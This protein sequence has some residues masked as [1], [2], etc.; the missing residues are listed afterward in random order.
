MSIQHQKHGLGSIQTF[1]ALPTLT[2]YSTGAVGAHSSG[3]LNNQ[4]Y[5]NLA[6]TYLMH[7]LG[8]TN[9]SVASEYTY[10]EKSCFISLV[11]SHF[12]LGLPACLKV[13]TMHNNMPRLCAILRNYFLSDTYS[14]I[15]FNLMSI[16]GAILKNTQLYEDAKS[17][18][19]ACI[20]VNLT[21]DTRRIL[22][23]GLRLPV[24]L[25]QWSPRVNTPHG[26][27]TPAD[28]AISHVC[29]ALREQHGI[30]KPW[31]WRLCPVFTCIACT[32]NNNWLCYVYEILLT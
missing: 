22:R 25:R 1:I 11:I 13:K 4:C 5:Q 26:Y 32:C 16:H 7:C 29:I 17:G 18:L 8:L 2:P 23:N 15:Q 31:P 19:I 3:Y 30:Q 24:P 27:T 9:I 20:V 6:L 14:S 28:G 12:Q 10:I 21:L